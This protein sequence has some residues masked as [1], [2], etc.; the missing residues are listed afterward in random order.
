[1]TRAAAVDRRTTETRINGRLTI[2]G[3]TL[4]TSARASASSTT[5]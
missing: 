2:D 3:R 4:T 1:M 5:C